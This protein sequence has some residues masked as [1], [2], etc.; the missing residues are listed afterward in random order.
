MIIQI[1]STVAYFITLILIVNRIRLIMRMLEIM[2]DTERMLNDKI[3]E[4]ANNPF[5]DGYNKALDN[6]VKKLKEQKE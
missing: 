3:N 4:V 2:A 1:I 5:C 6:V